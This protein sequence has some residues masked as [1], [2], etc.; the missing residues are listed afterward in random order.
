LPAGVFSLVFKS[1]SQPQSLGRGVLPAHGEYKATFHSPERKT[2]D[3]T[4]K[5]E[6]R[7]EDLDLMLKFF[8][9]VHVINSEPTHSQGLRCPAKNH[10]QSREVVW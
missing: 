10:C 7:D 6:G 4:L 3:L 1:E 9:L 5:W 2:P 8:P